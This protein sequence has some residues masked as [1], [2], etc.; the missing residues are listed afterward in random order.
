[1]K[2]TGVSTPGFVWR[3]HQNEANQDANLAKADAILGGTLVLANLA[4]PNALGPASAAGAPASPGNGMMTFRI[5]TVLNVGQTTVDNEGNFTP[6]E[7][8]PGIPGTT[9]AADGIVVDAT[10]F[11][12]LPAGLVTLGVNSDDGFRTTAGYLNDAPLLIG[13]VDGGRS[14]ADTLLQLGVQEAGTYAFRTVYYEG[15]GGAAFEWFMVKADGTKVLLNDTAN[16]G[17]RAYQQGTIP[18][19]PVAV[20][21]TARL[22]ANGKVVLEWPSGTLQSASV[23]NGTYQTVDGA[24]SPHE[25]NPALAAEK[26]YRVKVQ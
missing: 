23:V 22:N 11:L 10:A 5:P 19:M 16:G 7:Q 24:T 6:D 17:Y 1:M 2:A 12:D 21:I 14:A 9:A 3:M 13:Q 25:A 20:R 4:D 8:M 15:N 26:Y 18:S